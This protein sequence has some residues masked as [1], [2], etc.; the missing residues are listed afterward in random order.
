MMK[1]FMVAVGGGSGSGKT[2]VVRLLESYLSDI[3]VLVV[4]QDHYYLDLSHLSPAERNRRNFDH[5]EALDLVL[6]REQMSFLSQGHSI[7]RPT[8]DFATHTRS[9][10]TEELSPRP[11]IFFD[12]ILSLCDQNVLKHFDMSIYIDVPNDIRILRRLQRDVAERGRTVPSVIEQYLESVR[13]MH[14]DFVQPTKQLA[15]VVVEWIKRDEQKV[16]GLADTLRNR[17]KKC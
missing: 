5:P 2:T 13:P 17:V 14:E 7:K 12:G 4:S 8:Y 16:S 3:G 11:V 15:D 9:S 10:D 6:L 1:P